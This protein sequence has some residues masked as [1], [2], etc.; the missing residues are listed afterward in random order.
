[1]SEARIR[2]ISGPV[3]H[4]VALGPFVV[5]EAIEVGRARLPGEV[6]RLDGDTLVAQ[7]YEDTTGLKPGD[8][9]HGT[10]A[11]LSVALGPALPGRI[12]D[13]LLRRLDASAAQLVRAAGG[14]AAKHGRRPR[15]TGRRSNALCCRQRN[16]GATRRDP[17][18]ALG[19]RAGAIRRQQNCCHAPGAVAQQSIVQP[20]VAAPAE[21][22]QRLCAPDAPVQCFEH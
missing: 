6:I 5:G 11:P 19:D 1:M 9:V 8:P 18:R 20:G 2:A 7:V 16:G 12:Y 15:Q 4:A 3:L 13:G 10:T 14:I 17:K 22:V 21:G